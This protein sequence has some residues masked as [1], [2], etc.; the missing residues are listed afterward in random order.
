MSEVLAFVS[1]LA[2]GLAMVAAVDPVPRAGPAWARG[3]F[4]VSLA[5]AA[6]AAITSILFL[7]LRIAGWA[8][9]AVILAVESLCAI[10]GA[11]VW[12]RRRWRLPG[13]PSVAAVAKKA[14][15]IGIGRWALVAG[16]LIVFATVEIRLIQ[17]SRANPV[18]EWDAWAIWNLRARFLAGPFDWH[19][20][21]SPLLTNTHPEYPM[22]LSAFIAR[23]W[24]I[25]HS[26]TTAIP[27]ITG[28][29]FLDRKSVV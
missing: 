14:A 22:L 28:L 23:G 18:G 27:A 21:A 13:V 16:F 8:S 9:P 17:I 10:A 24:R 5:A 1:M 12:A 15:G 6:G 4:R 7:L 25:G 2:V 19:V 20:A 26:M 3:L 11:M 29:V